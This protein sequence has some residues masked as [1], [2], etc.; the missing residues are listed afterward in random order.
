M[1][2][3]YGGQMQQGYGAK[4]INPDE[5]VDMALKNVLNYNAKLMEQN[6][7]DLNKVKDMV[8][9][10]VNLAE[11]VCIGAGYINKKKKKLDMETL[12]EHE[13]L[14]YE[15]AMV[16][17]KAQ[18]NIFG[19]NIERFATRLLEQ[20]VDGEYDSK[21]RYM[22]EKLNASFESKEIDKSTEEL[23]LANYKFQLMLDAVQSSKPRRA[24]FNV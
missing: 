18:E 8:V 3:N 20:A 19:S 1:N 16:Y 7:I 13:T 4:Q 15:S 11:N 14:L 2:N 24:D 9:Y 10:L 21:V 12:D 17:F 5:Y 23:Q 22:R 6:I